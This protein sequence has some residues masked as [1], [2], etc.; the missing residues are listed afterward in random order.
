MRI[1]VASLHGCAVQNRSEAVRLA[2]RLQSITFRQI[3]EAEGGT[4][5][6]D[7]LLP[8]MTHRR[9]TLLPPARHDPA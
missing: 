7:W 1:L 6:L 8:H 4:L 2:S 5:D 3:K 9:G